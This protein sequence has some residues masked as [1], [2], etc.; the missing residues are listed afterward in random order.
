MKPKC[1]KCG[2]TLLGDHDPWGT[3]VVKCLLCGWQRSRQEST[4]YAELTVAESK[5]NESRFRGRPRTKGSGLFVHCRVMDCETPVETTRTSG[6]CRYCW[7]RRN[8]WNKSKHL[9]EPPFVVYPGDEQEIR[10]RLIWN[11]K[12][13]RPGKGYGARN[14]QHDQGM[15]VI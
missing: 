4:A 11:P 2:G 5:Q 3:L 6:L 10:P 8:T 13:P 12:K 1:E 7:T 15:R 9:T 14:V